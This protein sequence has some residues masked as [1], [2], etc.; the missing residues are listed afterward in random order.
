MI[1]AFQGKTRI[2]FC[3][4]STQ[5]RSMPLHH[6]PAETTKPIPSPFSFSAV[7]TRTEKRDRTELQNVKRTRIPQAENTADPAT[8]PG[9]PCFPSIDRPLSF[10]RDDRR[11]LAGLLGDELHLAVLEGEKREVT[12]TADV[13]AGVD[14]RA[15]LA[16]DDGTGL[17]KLAV[18]SIDTEILRVRVV[19]VAGRCGSRRY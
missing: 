14:L 15:A 2:V 17:E 3:D 11:V 10:D 4:T 6:S 19:S 1:P 9:P 5:A 18:V 12:T 7:R 16:N 13:G 8:V